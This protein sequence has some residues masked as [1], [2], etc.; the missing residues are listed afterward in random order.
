[1]RHADRP[2]RICRD[3]RMQNKDDHE[4]RSTDVEL[5]FCTSVV[6][7][8]FQAKFLLGTRNNRNSS[9]LCK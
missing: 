3:H 2:T 1:M 9:Q 6:I 7:G 4:V 8:S 5:H